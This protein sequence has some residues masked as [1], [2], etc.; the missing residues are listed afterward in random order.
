MDKK[1]ILGIVLIAAIFIVWGV[2]NQPSEK[3]K[4]KAQ[5]EQ[6]SLA[7]VRQ[8]QAVLQNKPSE[9]VKKDSI[10]ADSAAIAT[11][12][13]RMG[14]FG[15]KVY[16]E[17]KFYTIENDLLIL[18]VSSK[19][20]R[21]YSVE[22]KGFRTYDSLPL[23]LFNGDS[24][25]F[26]INFYDAKKNN[27]YTGDLFF[28][29]DSSRPANILVKG[30]ADSLIMTVASAENK[31]IEFVYT[32]TPGSYK[33]DMHI[34]VVGLA[35]KD[36]RTGFD[37]VSLNWEMYSPQQE[38]GWKNESMYTSLYYKPFGEDVNFLK[39]TK[40]V[41][42]EIKTKLD[43]IGYK[44]QFFSTVLMADNTFLNAKLESVSPEVDSKYIK[45][46]KSEIALPYNPQTDNNIGMSFYFGPN[47]YK[48]LKKQFG[49]KKLQ[50]LIVVGRSIIKWINQG[51]IINLFYLLSKWFG[52]YGIIILIMTIIIKMALLPLTFKSYLSTA[53]MKVLKPMIDEITKK[54][55]K[56]KTME[57]QQASM[58]VYRKV[59]VSPLGGCLPMLL[60]MPI[61]FA[62]FRFFP[63]AI[64]LRQQS[65]LW[66]TDLS[67]YDSIYSWTANIP[68]LSGI[69]GNHI[70][71][72]TILMTIT[73]LLSMK[74]SGT[75]QMND[76]QMPGMKTMMYIMPITFMFVLN[77][78]SSGLTYYYFLANVIT[79][80]QNYLFKAFV[81]DE[82]VLRKL[83]AKK[84]K[85]KKKSKWQQ[86][87]EDMQKQQQSL[88]KRKK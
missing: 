1:S 22:L 5:H 33:V 46:F 28:K 60:Q 45:H 20:G 31:Y 25:I 32:V 24:N 12:A 47:N 83:E 18:K 41:E 11:K 78:Y 82:E 87:I 58:S 6:D 81:D 66:A 3:D 10:F 70:S 48:L 55:P 69:Y 14:D 49:D 19:G 73:T 75:S 9:T 42:E 35:D 56:E 86:R 88:S 84:A 80:G 43:W 52:N 2:I 23:V 72:F 85:P 71:L 34:R 26:N 37:Y 65:F 51:V 57:R 21:P 79:I 7:I 53:K 39:N 36:D 15:T 63:V 40:T 76:S 8:Q 17:Q 62:M 77:R 44:D 29:P 64:E 67:T 27:I 16:G 50:D 61:L 54:I 38:Q 68:V 59:G 74:M 13:T 4:L 30:K